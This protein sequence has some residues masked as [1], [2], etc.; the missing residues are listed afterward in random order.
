MSGNE[1]KRAE[2]EMYTIKLKRK[3]SIRSLY[4]FYFCIL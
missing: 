3:K 1:E 2:G 4:Q